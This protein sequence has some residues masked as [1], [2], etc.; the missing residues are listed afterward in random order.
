MDTDKPIPCDNKP[1]PIEMDP[2]TYWWCSCGRS[3]N[4]PYCD[5]SHK[6]TAFAPVKVE[7]TEAKKVWWCL[8]KHTGQAPFCDGSHKNLP[9]QG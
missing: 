1:L 5:G 8:C 7:I 9:A 4:Q 2:G 3:S 6:G